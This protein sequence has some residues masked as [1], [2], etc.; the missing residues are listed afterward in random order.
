MRI[1]HVEI[2]GYAALAPMAGVADRAFRQ[3]CVDFGAA[4]TVGEMVSSKGLCFGEKKSKELLVLDASARPAAIQ[5]FGDDP[6]YMARAADMALAFQPDILDINFGCPAPKIVGNHCG[7]ALLKEPRLCEKIVRAVADAVPVPV[8]AKIRKG[9]NKD[10]DVAVEI[11]RACEAGGA[12]AVTVHGRTRAQMYAPPSDRECIRR[13]KAAVRIPVIANGD[14]VTAA[15][16][17]SMYEETGCDL[18]MIGRGA[19]GAPWLFT[20]IQALLNEGRT[21][22]PPPPSRR[23][24]VLYRQIEMAVS[25]KGEKVALLEARKHAA[26]YMR[27]LRGGAAYRTAAGKITTLE[28]LAELCARVIAENE[29]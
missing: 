29:E 21:L 25:F 26:W 1:G 2:K 11:A 15:D 4:Y 16:A 24:A 3:I 6:D 22:P 10:E 18:V 20:E 17:A 5:L 8:T 28:Q 27:G 19:L 12:A 13:V 14:I 23:M 7:S 9:F